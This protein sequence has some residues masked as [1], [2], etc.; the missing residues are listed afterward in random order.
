MH[1]INDE[2]ISVIE[3]LLPIFQNQKKVSY[4]ERKYDL[5]HKITIN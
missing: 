4:G 5:P 1:R 2:Y 3:L